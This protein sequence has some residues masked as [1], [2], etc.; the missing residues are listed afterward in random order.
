MQRREPGEEE[1]VS[2]TVR[3]ERALG[4]PAHVELNGPR[5][6]ARRITEK[7]RFWLPVVSLV[8]IPLGA[9]TGG[10]IGLLAAS[11]LSTSFRSEAIVVPAGRHVPIGQF[12]ALAQAVFR[13]DV[14]LQPVV[15]TLKLNVTS[16][17]LLASGALSAQEVPT[18]GAVSIVALSSDPLLSRDLANTAAQSL[19]E[20]MGA[21]NLGAVSVFSTPAP[22]EPQPRPSIAYGVLGTVSGAVVGLGLL[23]TAKAIGWL[24]SAIHTSR[25]RAEIG[26]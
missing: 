14:V 24:R 12:A 9:L 22:G 13:T 3:T 11:N 8:L 2:N 1:R 5:F 23:L 19:V 16:H 10:G 15:S 25:Q 18:G 6:W 4:P 26:T 21:H 17:E 7:G 20:A